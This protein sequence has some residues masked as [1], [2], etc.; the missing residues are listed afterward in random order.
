ME[1]QESSSSSSSSPE[2][3]SK[4]NHQKP[5]PANS[6]VV[7][8]PKAQRVGILSEAAEFGRLTRLNEHVVEAVAGPTEVDDIVEKS[9][10]PPQDSIYTTNTFQMAVQEAAERGKLRRLK[11]V[12]IENFRE[13]EKEPD[14][15]LTTLSQFKDDGT[16][17]AKYLEDERLRKHSESPLER[18]ERQREA[19]EQVKFLSPK[20][21]HKPHVK[22]NIPLR[23]RE[24]VAKLAAQQSHDRNHRIQNEKNE[25]K[26]TFRCQCPHCKN[27]SPFQTNFYK[28]LQKEQ[29]QRIKSQRS[30]A[31]KKEDESAAQKMTPT[32]GGI[33][34]GEEEDDDEYDKEEDETKVDEKLLKLRK[35]VE[36]SILVEEERRNKEEADRLKANKHANIQAAKAILEKNLFQPKPEKQD[37]K[38]EAID[39]DVLYSKTFGKAYTKISKRA[40]VMA[41]EE[42]NQQAT[43]EEMEQE[44]LRQMTELYDRQDAGEKIDEERLYELELFDRAR[45]DAYLSKAEQR[46]LEIYAKRRIRTDKFIEEYED[47]M[48]R[49]NNGEEID[50]HRAYQLEYVVKKRG[51]SQDLTMAEESAMIQFETQEYLNDGLNPDDF[52]TSFGTDEDDEDDEM[53]DDEDERDGDDRSQEEENASQDSGASSQNSAADARSVPSIQTKSTSDV[54]DAIESSDSDSTRSSNSSQSS[55]SND[56]SEGDDS[57]LSYYEKDELQDLT[58]Y[59][60]SGEQIDM[61]RYMDLFL[62]DKWKNGGTLD[63]KEMEHLNIY[64]RKRKVERSYRNEFAD[65]VQMQATGQAF[66]EE[67]FYLLQL[68]ARRQVGQPLND[69]ET[70][71]LIAFEEEEERRE[72]ER[73]EQRKAKNPSPAKEETPEKSDDDERSASSRESNDSNEDERM[74]IDNGPSIFD[75]VSRRSHVMDQEAK[76][77]TKYSQSSKPDLPDIGDEE[78]EGED[79]DSRDWSQS[80]ASAG[81]E[82]NHDQSLDGGES[83]AS[84]NE[85]NNEEERSLNDNGKGENDDSR[86]WSQSDASAAD[87]TND[88]QLLG[89]GESDVPKTVQKDEEE[90]PLSDNGKDENDDSWADAFAGDV[91]NDDQLSHGDESYAPKTEQKD[92]KERHLSDNGKDENDDS[93]YLSPDELNEYFRL[94][95]DKDKGL[96]VDGDRLQLLRLINMWQF[97]ESMSVEQEFKLDDFRRKRRKSRALHREF[98]TLLE[99]G[100]NGEE[101]DED[102]IYLLELF[103]RKQVGEKLTEDEVVLL[104]ELEEKEGLTDA[105]GELPPPSAMKEVVESD[106]ELYCVV[107]DDDDSLP[108]TGEFEEF[109]ELLGRQGSHEEFDEKRLHALQLLMKWNNGDGLDTTQRNDLASIRYQRRKD[110]YYKREFEDLL[111]K[112]DQ[113][114]EVDEDRI[115]FLQLYARRLLGEHLSYDEVVELQRFED[116]EAISFEKEPEIAPKRKEEPSTS[117]SEVDSNEIMAAPAP[118]HLSEADEDSNHPVLDPLE[119]VSEADE[120]S[121]KSVPDPWSNPIPATNDRE[122]GDAPLELPEDASEKAASNRSDDETENIHEKE[123]SDRPIENAPETLSESDS[124]PQITSRDF[125]A[126]NTVPESD[127]TP[128]TTPTDFGALKNID[129]DTD[130]K[131]TTRDHAGSV[132][133]PTAPATEE[134]SQMELHSVDERSTFP[135]S[136]IEVMHEYMYQ[137]TDEGPSALDGHPPRGVGKEK[138]SAIPEPIMAA[139]E[140]N[141]NLLK[142]LDAAR[143]ETHEA[144]ERAGQEVAK[145]A[146]AEDNAKYAESEAM[147]AKAALAT[148]EQQRLSYAEPSYQR[149]R[150]IHAIGSK[151]KASDV[152]ESY[153]SVMAFNTKL[154]EQL[155]DARRAALEATQQANEEGVRRAIAEESAKKAET[156][157]VFA[158]GVLATTAQKRELP[159]SQPKEMS[160]ELLKPFMVAM[161][162]NAKLLEQLDEARKEALEAKTR[163]TKEKLK[164]AAAEDNAKRFAMEAEKATIMLLERDGTIE[165]ADLAADPCS[166]G[167]GGTSEMSSILNT[168]PATEESLADKAHP[169]E[170]DPEKRAQERR[171][172]AMRVVA[173]RR[174]REAEQAEART[175]AETLEKEHRERIRIA[176]EERKRKTREAMEARKQMTYERAMQG[177]KSYTMLSNGDEALQAAKRAKEL[178][179]AK[180][181]REEAP[182]PKKSDEASNAKPAPKYSFEYLEPSVQNDHDDPPVQ[183][184]N[185]PPGTQAVGKMMSGAYGPVQRDPSGDALR[186]K[187]FVDR[188]VT[189]GPSDGTKRVDSDEITHEDWYSKMEKVAMS[190]TTEHGQDD[191]QHEESNMSPED[192]YNE[193]EALSRDSEVESNADSD[194]KRAI[195][196]AQRKARASNLEADDI[197]NEMSEDIEAIRRDVMKMSKDEAVNQILRQVSSDA[198]NKPE[199]DSHMGRPSAFDLDLEPSTGEDADYTMGAPS[200]GSSVSAGGFELRSQQASYQKSHHTSQSRS[201]R[202]SA[203]LRKEKN[204]VSRVPASAPKKKLVGRTK[205]NCMKNISWRSNPEDSFSDWKVEIKHKETGKVDVYHLHRNVLG[206]GVRKSEYFAAQFQED[207]VVNGYYET[208]SPKVTQLD[209]PQAWANIFPMVLDFLYHNREKTLKLTA[210]R[211]CAMYKWAE[212]LGIPALKTTIVEFYNKNISLKNFGRFIAS[213]VQMKAGPL[214]VAS[215]SKIGRL[216]TQQP[217]QAWRLAPQFLV[218]VLEANRKELINKAKNKEVQPQAFQNASCKWSKAIYFCVSK[219]KKVVTHKIFCDLTSETAIPVID[220]TVAL[221]LLIL[222]VELL[223]ADD[224]KVYSKFQKRCVKSIVQNWDSFRLKYPNQTALTSALQKLPSDV[225][226][227]ILILS[228]NRGKSN[229]QTAI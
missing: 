141:A 59:K 84:E 54:P 86:D 112:G 34:E 44:D 40:S 3:S 107:I 226:A 148:A 104:N 219:N 116:D 100:E 146:A 15:N 4:S 165:A 172:R 127:V 176:V 156:D 212:F 56:D 90:H 28:S 201:S 25:L 134:S 147:R 32:L 83:T 157:V 161:E 214:V 158:R 111:A 208:K 82:T 110:R 222:D 51:L 154:L 76:A 126:L 101:V 64:R 164:R 102:R 73:R 139:M 17:I 174:Q 12:V 89:G 119:Q 149:N 29:L 2:S 41:G 129:E 152:P 77:K 105:E 185:D 163:A 217:N 24:D 80:D 189:K 117:G 160:P 115:Y 195:E 200:E 97:G 229:P 22:T 136:V 13:R 132:T 103:A 70:T 187:I 43:D 202:K 192:W 47:V 155:N 71:D 37:N 33:T 194:M 199:Q 193:I 178:L 210:N 62:F 95:E 66:D 30:F 204:Q 142:E 133:T 128:Q 48:S 88:D 180:R 46:D 49:L 42:W 191:V 50:E 215:K 166:V 38:V 52:K 140:A 26:V 45:R 35:Q 65:M 96:D 11:P 92:E 197:D 68:F 167:K 182:A 99:R 9:H 221:A 109:E 53:D 19:L 145:R 18:A 60:E 220:P 137:E 7:I 94:I 63:T 125:T 6:K 5:L 168:Q 224:N 186:S 207:R 196:E 218:S 131:P 55:Q 58:E 169:V 216:V 151:E 228:N 123:S 188:A 23:M 225:L 81:D 78:D 85:Q 181:A 69:E 162:A 31:G 209:L 36:A 118:E 150:N 177:M 75:H 16:R 98:A 153:L 198:K 223:A 14:F 79:D 159:S 135:S 61:N 10:K 87:A 74:V 20:A 8:L 114:N 190:H 184:S 106:S 143:L 122:D 170:I 121:N 1:A 93:S 183:S 130:D 120:D 67:R 91:A 57:S 227:E 113:G 39:P 179:Q 21:I 173:E 138:G 27:A 108:S 203:R 171:E 124:T 144:R 72:E 206:Y 211:S 213:A 205:P 175:E